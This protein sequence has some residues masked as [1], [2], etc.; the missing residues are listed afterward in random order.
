MSLF[1]I[2]KRK[3]I[4]INSI[5][6]KSQEEYK[7]KITIKGKNN[8][9][10][11]QLNIIKNNVNNNLGKE[12]DNYLCITSDEEFIKY[13]KQAVND[14]IVAIDTE[15]DSLDS[16]KAHLVGVCLYSESQK[17]AYIPVG[18][19]SA[20]TETKV[21]PQ[22]SIEAITEGMKILKQ[23]KCIFHNSYYDRVVIY[24][25]T[26]ILL[27]VYDDT[28]IMAWYLNENEPHGL[29][30]L[31]DKYIAE[32]KNGVHT[33]SDLFDGVPFCY[34]PYDIG[35]IYGAFDSIMTYKLYM[36]FKQFLT[37]GSVECEEYG[38]QR[39]ANVYNEVEKPLMDVLVKMKIQGVRFDFDRAKELK[40]KYL[41]LKDNA[42][43]E[44]N[45]A[46]SVYES[47]IRDRIEIR[48]DIEYPINYNS[49]QQISILF[50]DIIKTGVIFKK[51]PRGTGKHVLEEI[52]NNKKYKDTPLF[53][54]AQTLQEVKK[55][56]KL[57][58]SFI[59]KLSE[60]AREHN[61]RIFCDFNQVGANCVVADTLLLTN[62]GYEYIGDLVKNN[63]GEIE[64][65]DNIVVVNRYGD[66]EKVSHTYRY[67]NVD[68]IKI[69]TYYGFEIEGTKNHPV[70]IDN[71]TFRE[72]G[73]LKL[74]DYIYVPYGY[75]K[76]PTKYL[77]L[78]KEINCRLRGKSLDM[79]NNL[80]N[81]LNEDIAEFLG[82][83]HADGSIA[84]SNGS[85]RVSIE[86]HN[87]KAIDN[88]KRIMK[89]VFGLMPNI[90]TS[91]NK[92]KNMNRSGIW[93]SGVGIS[94]LDNYMKH[95]ARNKKVPKDI[96]KSPQSVIC[97]YLRGLCLDSS[98]YYK[99]N[100]AELSISIY[101]KHD[102]I[103][104][105]SFLLNLGILSSVR[106]NISKVRNYYGSRL[107]INDEFLPIFFQKIGT[108]YDKQL[109]T[110]KFTRK[111][112]G[113]RFT[114]KGTLF[115]IKEISYNKSN[116]YD[117]HLPNTHSFISNGVV[118]HN[119]LRLSSSSPNLQQVPSR[120]SDIR[121]MFIP[122]KDCVFVN[123]DFSQQEM[124]A[125]ASLAD[126]DKMLNS[127]HLGRD[128]YSHVASI[129][130]NV[131]YEDCLE[132]Y[133]DGTVNKEGKTRRK[134]S[135]AICLGGQTPRIVEIL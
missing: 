44:F 53:N 22:V 52:I 79:Y 110:F 30:Y 3:E 130:F 128:I 94:W 105:Q 112:H 87:P 1:A 36:F 13:C 76:F 10:M 91:Y 23:A 121:N 84:T 116:V 65:E 95:G 90:D 135:K 133:P 117:L 69:R 46:V 73:D 12:K 123:L 21:N 88:I 7:P 99:H 113:V 14:G 58:G 34:I 39:V 42:I 25:N 54:I 100:H 80:P 78:K 81:I 98:I 6:E 115:M 67:D 86:N 31:Y 77:P 49:P 4:D 29:K 37:I 32:G 120:N 59:D 97:A 60:N 132:F 70:M 89:K 114:S 125:V 131:P 103:F 27:D 107:S 64:K 127:F 9:L 57:I 35:Y 68:T 75:N 45:K 63:S 2:P 122:E 83:Y 126:D 96:Y 56:D 85:Y 82:M 16:I 109:E 104:F 8:T 41:K 74:G 66:Y 40:I 26:G 17:P 71:N 55:Y 92:I 61:G 18:H 51:E 50:Y 102:A 5:L 19:I 118:S 48:Q 20:I 38:L 24:Q 129:A 119:T 93:L 124:M 72:L 33:F 28:L 47:E 15:T 11:A 134:K 62:N 43:E 106:H 108:P 111:Y 101:D